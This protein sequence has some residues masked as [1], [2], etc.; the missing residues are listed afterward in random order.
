VSNDFRL[1]SN[2]SAVHPS[3]SKPPVR[4]LCITS[5]S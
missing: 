3:V 1:E 4:D 5:G 2:F